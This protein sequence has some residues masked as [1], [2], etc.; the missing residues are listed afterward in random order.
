MHNQDVRQTVTNTSKATFVTFRR[1]SFKI[2]MDVT[3]KSTRCYR[4][5]NIYEI[6]IRTHTHTHTQ[7]STVANTHTHTHTH[8]RTQIFVR[9]AFNCSLGGRQRHN[10]EQRARRYSSAVNGVEPS[11]SRSAPD[12]IDS[13]P[14][15]LFGVS[16]CREYRSISTAEADRC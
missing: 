6:P 2:D 8:P 10:N 13:R 3:D 4:H 11:L 16:E 14:A 7:I 1:N 12:I 9:K 5:F 15:R